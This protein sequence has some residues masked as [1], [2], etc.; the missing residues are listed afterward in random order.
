MR[1]QGA[2]TP[3]SSGICG[4]NRR[5]V[6]GVA[7]LGSALRSGRRGPG[8]ESRLP[9]HL[10]PSALSCDADT[11]FDPEHA[12]KDRAS[13][14]GSGRSPGFESRLPHRDYSVRFERSHFNR[15][16][17]P[18]TESGAG[19]STARTKRVISSGGQESGYT[20][21]QLN[22]PRRPTGAEICF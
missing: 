6:R 12:T 8:F 13:R 15:S 22:R 16:T 5:P 11:C 20:G 17:R 14:L 7:Q 10:H 1:K 9:D 4:Y 3:F 19:A 18:A 21:G 2:G